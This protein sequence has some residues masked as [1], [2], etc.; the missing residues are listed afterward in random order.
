[1]TVDTGGYGD[2]HGAMTFLIRYKEQFLLDGILLIITFYLG[3]DV[4]LR[5]VFGLPMIMLLRA[6]L[7]FETSTLLCLSI[8]EKC[9]ITCLDTI[10]IAH[11][12]PAA[13]C[14]NI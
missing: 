6:S 10:P 12:S 1:M 4:S 3:N 7:N 9:F 8:N 14:D 2:N 11:F 13:Q 5:V